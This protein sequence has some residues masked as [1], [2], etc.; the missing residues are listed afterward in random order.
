MRGFTVLP[1]WET[2]DGNDDDETGPTNP[3]ESPGSEVTDS[4]GLV[5]EVEVLYAPA[6]VTRMFS[7][8]VLSA[9]LLT[10]VPSHRIFK[11]FLA[12]SLGFV[13]GADEEEVL[14]ARLR[15]CSLAVRRRYR[16]GPV[17]GREKV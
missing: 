6:G 10:P 12:T 16:Y 14:T 11:I 3:P 9:L 2:G 1:A 17:L 8:V 7:S 13:F 15:S 5:F 4:E